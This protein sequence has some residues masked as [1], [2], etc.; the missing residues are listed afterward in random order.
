MSLKIELST[1]NFLTQKSY[2][3]SKL[4]AAKS[5]AEYK[6]YLAQILA[7]FKKEEEQ[8]EDK[9]DSLSSSNQIPQEEEEEPHF[10]IQ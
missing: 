9:L 1:T 4:A 10:E 5:R 2:A 6:K 7:D 3:N 8:E